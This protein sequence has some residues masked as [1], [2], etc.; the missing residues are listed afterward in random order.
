MPTFTYTAYNRSGKKVKGTIEA[1]SEPQAIAELSQKGFVVV[2]IKPGGRGKGITFSRNG[3]KPKKRAL[4]TISLD[5]ISIFTSQFSTMVDAGVRIRDAL[6]VLSEQEVFSKRFRKVLK[7]VVSAI[8]E[9]K[10]LSEAFE[11]QGVFD[12]VLVNLVKAGEEGGVLDTTMAKAA[13]FYETSKNL[14]D[15]IKA[16]MRYP[17]FVMGFAFLVIIAI[18]LFI[19]PNLVA[20]LNINPTGIVGALMRVSDF[21]KANWL[22]LM[23]GFIV[24][25]VGF[26]F[27]MMTTIGKRLKETVLGLIPPVKKMRDQMALERFARTLGVLVGAGVNLPTALE[28]AAVATTSEKFMRKI[29][30]VIR[31]VKEGYTLRDAF[32]KL[33]VVPQLVYEMVGTGETTGK[34]EEVLEKVANFYEAQVRVSVKKLVSMIEPTMIMVIGG[35]IAFIA[36]SLYSTMFQAQATFGGGM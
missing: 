16:S 25:F 2:D 4:F 29:D 36:F 27:L 33:K 31:L 21:V 32:A 5:E 17:M 20:S 35:F 12:P 9:G 10:S 30:E 34:L 6:F 14:Q 1:V 3:A 13:Q 15:E 28:M 22:F 18:S 23:I 19:I 11:E 26:K 8:E 24:A 7:E